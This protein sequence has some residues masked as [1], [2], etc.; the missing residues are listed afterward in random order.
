MLQIQVQQ[1]FTK[2][3]KTVIRDF[4]EKKNYQVLSEISVF[5][6]AVPHK[7]ISELFKTTKESAIYA[8]NNR[9]QDVIKSTN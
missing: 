4:P 8:T 2:I 5:L 1:Q 3:S 7:E 9:N 6:D